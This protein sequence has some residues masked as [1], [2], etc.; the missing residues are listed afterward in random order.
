[1]HINSNEQMHKDTDAAPQCK[2]TCTHTKAKILMILYT[3]KLVNQILPRSS[4]YVHAI[5]AAS[6]VN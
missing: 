3:L 4:M 6:L 1:M 2:D 5:T